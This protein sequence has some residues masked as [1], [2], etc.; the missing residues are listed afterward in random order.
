MHAAGI[1]QIVI[2]CV[3][4]TLVAIPLGAYMAR[5]FEGERTW[6]SPV[7]G[8]IERGVYRVTGIDPSKEQHWTGYAFSVL[9]FSVIGLLVTYA[10]MRL[11]ALLPLNPAGQAAVSP[12]LAF[13]TAVSFTTN[14]NWQNYGGE[15]HHELS[16]PDARHDG[17]QLYLG[18]HRHGRARRPGAR[19]RT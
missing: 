18:G 16:D 6:L 17:A 13:N 14:T 7:I 3:I 9:A 12:D 2:Y 15:S 5:V 11:Q 19:F 8:P 1:L 10:V 4:V